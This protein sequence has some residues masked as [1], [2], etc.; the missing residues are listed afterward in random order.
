[1]L[2]SLDFSYFLFRPPAGGCNKNRVSPLKPIYSS[3]KPPLTL[4]NLNY[5]N[6]L[7]KKKGN[8]MFPLSFF[9][10]FCY[11]TA[12]DNSAP[13]LNLTTFLAAI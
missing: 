3:R 4:N 11:D 13:A 1:M 7:H 5:N 12:P 6:F 10:S 9:V 2:V 8:K